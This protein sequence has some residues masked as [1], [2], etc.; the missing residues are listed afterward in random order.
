L[1]KSK[2]C[3]NPP[4]KIRQEEGGQV[5]GATPFGVSFIGG[6]LKLSKFENIIQGI[7]SLIPVLFGITTIIVGIGVVAGSEPGYKVFR[8]LLI[9]NTFMGLVYVIAG[10][11]AWRNINRGKYASAGIFI[12]NLLVLGTIS[13]IYVLGNDIAI[14]SVRAMIFRTSIW[15]SLFVSYM[16]LSYRNKHFLDQNR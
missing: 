10:I 7:L 11:L 8:P 12:L 3:V 9:Y 2:F 15:F 13:Y 4:N 1:A 5:A 6:K 14:E 16:W